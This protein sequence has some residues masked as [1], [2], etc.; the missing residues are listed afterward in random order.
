[1]KTKNKIIIFTV[2]A[3]AI[4]GGIY[5]SRGS[6]GNCVKIKSDGEVIEVIDLDKVTEPYYLNVECDGFNRIYV[7]NGKIGVV[8]ADCPDRICIKQSESGIFPVVC[9]PHKLVIEKTESVVK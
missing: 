7:E 1:M 4:A 6:S 9:L 5:L 2:A 3:A 8:E